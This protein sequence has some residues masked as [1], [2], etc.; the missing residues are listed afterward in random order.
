MASPDLG[1]YKRKFAE[2]RRARLVN[3]CCL[4][5]FSRKREDN[6]DAYAGFM[7]FHGLGELGSETVYAT[8]LECEASHYS[9]RTLRR[10]VLARA[11]RPRIDGKSFCEV[12]EIDISI[13]RTGIP[14]LAE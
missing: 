4:P 11:R 9:N 2:G 14:E 12:S 7:M 10:D 13:S 5:L 6:V 8:G 3:K 1:F